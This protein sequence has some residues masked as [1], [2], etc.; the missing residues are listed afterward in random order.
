MS[1]TKFFQTA[2][3]LLVLAFG[4]AA[5]WA[6]STTEGAIGGTIV[7]QQGA[8]VPNAKVTV[9]NT[10]TN[11][12]FATTT[13]ETGAYRATHLQPG[14]YEVKI[15]AAGFA[16]YDQKNVVVEIGRI[17]TI[18]PKMSVTGSSETVTV[19]GEAPTINTESP[20]FASNVNQ[21]QI[22]NLPING[23]R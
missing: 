23:R 4:S 22:N 11:Q 13:S 14:I 18:D 21:V 12:Q 15:D 17:T 19:S 16:A 6:Q 10:G 20:D 9:I 3:L 7:D 1:R 5:A 8:V 2:I